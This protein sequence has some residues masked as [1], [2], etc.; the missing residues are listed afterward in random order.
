[1][2]SQNSVQQAA[3]AAAERARR[4]AIVQQAVRQ[5]EHMKQTLVSKGMGP[6]RVDKKG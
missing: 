1:M 6:A 3:D 2:S 5:A 4:A